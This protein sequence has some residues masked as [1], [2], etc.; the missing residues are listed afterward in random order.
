MTTN[1]QLVGV[2]GQGTILTSKILSEGLLQLGYDVKMSEIHGMAQRGGSV[3]T[4]IKFGDKVYSPIIDVGEADVIV[5]F[6]KSEAARYLHYLKPTGKLIINNCEIFPLSVLVGAESYPEQ[7]IEQ[8]KEKAQVIVVE[9]E[10]IANELGNNRV[11]NI[12]L[13]GA[14]VKALG[15]D[16]VDWIQI[17]NKFIPVSLQEINSKALKL[18]L[19]C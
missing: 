10:K 1:I 18:G 12:V 15:L 11:Q 14:V 17:M 9:G 4:Q 8:I 7:I 2:G 5:A 3:T 13:L 6:E 19:E 16:N